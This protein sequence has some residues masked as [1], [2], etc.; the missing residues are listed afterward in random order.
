MAKL[1][2]CGAEQNH[3]FEA[4]KAAVWQMYKDLKAYG[5]EPTQERI[6]PLRA[7]FDAIVNRATG[8]PELDAA[9]QRMAKKK[10]DLLR[11]L[12]RPAMPLHTNTAERD[13][14][15]WA[16]KRKISAGT[17]RELGQRCRDTFLSLKS[18]CRKLGVRFMNYLRDRIEK[19]GLIPVLA[20]LARHKA[21]NS[22]TI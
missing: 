21:T 19:A 4:V 3:A 9:L 17:R 11:V 6:E 1:V 15:D 10:D 7:Q 18:T 8:W 2:P 22:E 13:F 5:S 14:R 20:E 16:T 12:E